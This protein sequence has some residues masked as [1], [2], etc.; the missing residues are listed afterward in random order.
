LPG[1]SLAV[2]TAPLQDAQS[3]CADWIL[4]RVGGFRVSR[5]RDL[6]RQGDFPTG[7]ESKEGYP[8]KP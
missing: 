5:C 8:W 4:T 6:N 3:A 2:Q 1:D 7:S